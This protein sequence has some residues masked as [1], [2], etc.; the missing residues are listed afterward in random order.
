M[1]NFTLSQ[2]KVVSIHVGQDSIR[3]VAVKKEGKRAVVLAASK[4][5]RAGEDIARDI[6]KLFE[7]KDD[8]KGPGVIVTDQVRF[9]ASELNMAGTEKLSQDKLNAAATWEME[10]YLDFPPSEGIF[11]CQLLSYMAREDAVPVLISAMARNAYSEFSRGL[12]GCGMDVL[13]AYSPEGAL[14]Y[15]SHLPAEGKNKVIID[16]RQNAI[17][18]LCLTAKGPSVFQDLPVVAGA[19]PEDE[20][21]RNM[22]YDLTASVGGAEE[23]VITGSGV[24]EELVH[25]LK[26]ELQNVRIWGVEDFGGVDFDPAVTDFGP[27]YAL[28]VGAA[29]Q[30]LG[31]AGKV[32]LG[33]TDRVPVI[34]TV[35]QKVRENRRLVP[36]FAIGLFLLCVAG[37]YGMTKASIS[38]YASKVQDLKVEE[39]RLL[40]PIEEKKRLKKEITEI[41]QKQEYLRVVLPGRNINLLNLLAAISEKI[42]P[43]V[44]LNR[45]HQEEDGSFSIEGNAFRGRSVTAFNKALSELEGCEATC[46][47]TVNRTEDAS[48]PRKRI[49]PYNFVI[50]VKFELRN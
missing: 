11:A 7:G 50:S 3:V 30:E 18:G 29:L 15:A 23:V 33:V 1:I 4:I 26:T 17:K 12:K 39:K 20:P 6:A 14:A 46:L 49:L 31:L 40:Q 28:A 8:L 38:R 43:D 45:V 44:A 25:G 32:S 42:P 9:L 5:D 34:E 37:H 21:V 48:D 41:Q 27:K 35:I 19:G 10:P 36:A 16:Y 24:S 2:K 13:R 47:E 22:I